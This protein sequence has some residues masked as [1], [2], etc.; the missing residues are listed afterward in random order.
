ML[1]YFSKISFFQYFISFGGEDI[2]FG[3]EASPPSFPVDT[4]LINVN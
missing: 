1:L 3:V 2:V 4:T